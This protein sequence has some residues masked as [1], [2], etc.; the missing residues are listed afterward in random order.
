MQ[1]I[2]YAG[3]L[4]WGHFWTGQWNVA[5]NCCSML[6]SCLQLL[7]SWTNLP[8]LVEKGEK[9][10][11]WSADWSGGRGVSWCRVGE[12]LNWNV[13]WAK[14]SGWAQCAPLDKINQYPSA[15]FC[16]CHTFFSIGATF[17]RYDRTPDRN[18]V[19]LSGPDISVADNRSVT[20]YG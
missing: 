17:H 13:S 19:V 15:C 12:G 3:D 9:S 4:G 10:A 5:Y 16:H 2:N 11:G 18:W 1:V 7:T 20:S 6:F 14:V 8:W